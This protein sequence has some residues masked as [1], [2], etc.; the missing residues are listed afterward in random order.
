MA[1]P[2]HVLV[3]FGGR[4]FGSEIWNC[5]IRLG[6]PGAPNDEPRDVWAQVGPDIVDDVADA[7]EAWYTR[8]ESATSGL[9]RLDYV[10]VNGIWTDG[11]YADEGATTQRLYPTDTA[12]DGSSGGV[13]WPQIAVV[14]SLRTDVTRGLAAR[15]RVYV[16][17]VVGKDASTGRIPTAT[18]A[19]L[20]GS[21]AQ[22][23]RDLNAVET[24]LVGGG[25]EVC[26]V[27]RGRPE[28]AGF[29][30]GIARPVTRVEVG[31][32]IDTQ[33]RRRNDLVEVYTGEDI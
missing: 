8:V 9:S 31:N 25:L 28:G 7:V 19:E 16:P 26:V 23:V 18:T 33:R 20:A 2:P 3:S 12:P 21:F 15:G 13:D 10:K 4:F 30:A 27:S 29:S 22:L 24:I 32:V 11:Q 14:H 6:S 17:A 5:G 1:Y